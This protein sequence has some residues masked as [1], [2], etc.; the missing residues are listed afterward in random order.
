MSTTY[1]R[2][3]RRALPP[4]AALI[5]LLGP[6]SLAHASKSIDERRPAD[7]TGVVEVSNLAGSVEFDAWD[8]PEVQV[9]GTVDDNVERVDLNVTGNR[10]SINVVFGAGM[11]MR[12]GEARLLIHVPATSSVS[13]TLVSAD[14]KVSGIRGDVKLQTVSGDMSGDVGGDLHASTVNGDVRMTARGARTIEI[15]T[16]SGNIHLSGGSGEVDITTVSGPAKVA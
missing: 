12:R 15:K 8:R 9:T 16:I 13:A 2:I 5:V 3:R 14:I 4:A 7:P 1:S 6:W 10:T 11:S